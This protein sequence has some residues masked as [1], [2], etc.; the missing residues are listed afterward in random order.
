M[1]DRLHKNQKA[2]LA[3]GL[4]L[5]ILFGFFL[6]KGKVTRYDVIIGQLLLKDFTVVK[7][8][9]TAVLTG[10]L[11]V[12]A[13]KSVG[14]ARL[15]PKGGSVG[16]SLVGGLIFGV[17]FGILGYCPGTV[18]GA[19]GQG[20]LDAFVGGIGGIIF[21]SGLF[22]VF[23]PG[24]KEGILK[25]GAF[26]SKTFPELFKVNPWVVVIPAALMVAGLLFWIYSAG[27]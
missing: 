12:H 13:L 22:A 24:L 6:Q 4:V 9:L 16:A 21:G 1:L 15:H 26:P 27:L 5:G 3:L 17:G 11:C 14:L 2:Q 20:S 8:M 19:I 25:K 10:M 18:A 23:F 7:I